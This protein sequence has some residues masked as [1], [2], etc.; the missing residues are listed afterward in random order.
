[1]PR[2]PSPKAKSLDKGSAAC[3]RTNFKKFIKIF[4]AEIKKMQEWGMKLLA[5]KAHILGMEVLL[6]DQVS[7]Q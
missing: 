7:K 3:C 1:M 4:L 2:D 5:N 6:A